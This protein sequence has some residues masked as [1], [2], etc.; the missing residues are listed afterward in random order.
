MRASLRAGRRVITA[1]KALVATHGAALAVLATQARTT[2][3]FEGA[4]GGSIPVVRAL[5][6]GAAGVGLRAVRGLL[7]GTANFVLGRIRAGATLESA[8]C[9]AQVR[10]F[11][12]AVPDRDL[13]GR[14]AAD[15]IAIL[16]WLAFGVAPHMLAVT[17]R[18]IDD[19]IALS[20]TATRLGCTVRQLAEVELTT[21]GLVASVEPALVRRSHP[22]GRADNEW[23]AVCIESA[24]AGSLVL[25]GPGAGGDATAGALYADIGAASATLPTP[26]LTHHPLH[27]P[28]R[29]SWILRSQADEAAVAALAAATGC[30]GRCAASE[31]AVYEVTANR[32]AINALSDRLRERGDTPAL[33][34]DLR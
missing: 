21:A 23:N 18:P 11:A 29:L 27:D 31:R 6:A 28:R 5:R 13:D 3:D 15:K 4:V 14:D 7:N 32:T 12:E 9:E 24:S 2:I 22:L 16:A 25:A 1:N 33:A 20:P 34:R 17:R 19:A 26:S 8:V 10:G 30:T